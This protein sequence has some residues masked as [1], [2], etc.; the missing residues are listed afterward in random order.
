MLELTGMGSVLRGIGLLYWA[1][2]IGA[3][4]LAIRY[5][6][7]SRGKN[8]W[9][10][11]AIA[12][13]SYLPGKAMIERHRRDA[14]ANEAWAYFK[15]LC[16]EKSGEKIYKTYSG[17]KSVLVVKPLPPATDND[18]YDQFWYG[19]PYS[20]A[21]PWDR[22]GEQKAGTF[23][24]QQEFIDGRGE[25]GFE[26]FEQEITTNDGKA[27][28][29]VE[30]SQVPPYFVSKS[31][32]QKPASR[33]GVS[34]EDIS[35]SDDRKF[36]VAGSRFRVI[37]LIDKSIVAERIGFFIEAGFGSTAGQRTPWLTSRG[38]STTCPPLNNRTYEDRWFILKVLNPIEGSRD[39]K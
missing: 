22:R 5:G 35:T 31:P 21:T 9:A 11:V 8:I 30:P 34:W 3:V 1:L 15:K 18:L 23:I 25:I 13:F 32:V 10:A 33:F 29:R 24:G 39:G 6:K 12:A 28:Q 26:F 14:Y 19:D 17:V 16:D 20:N 37:D 4:F 38:P 2:A 36:W 7:G 27:F